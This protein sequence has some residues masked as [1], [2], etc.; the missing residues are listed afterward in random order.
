[1]RTSLRPGLGRGARLAE[2]AAADLGDHL[3]AEGQVV[4]RGRLVVPALVV[5]PARA[6]GPPVSALADAACDGL[7]GCPARCWLAQKA[8]PLL[9]R[10]NRCSLP[11]RPNCCSSPLASHKVPRR[12]RKRQARRLRAA[13]PPRRPGGSP[14]APQS[15]APAS[16]PP[17]PA[18]ARS[19]A[20]ATLAAPARVGRV[21]VP[22]P[23]RRRMFP[24]PPAVSAPQSAC[25]TCLPFE[26]QDQ[27]SLPGK[28]RRRRASTVG[29]LA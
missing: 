25:R 23:T 9:A 8:A 19:A 6:P 27:L 10:P 3:V 28:H 26:S 7:P 24:H 12:A 22:Y 16:R 18:P 13:R 2:A 4:A 21:K 20:C 1:M 15:T 5:P 11:A 17:R 14:A 29:S